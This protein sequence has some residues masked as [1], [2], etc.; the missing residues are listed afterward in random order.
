[1]PLKKPSPFLTAILLL[2][3]C[4]RVFAFETVVIDPGHGGVDQGSQ[5]YHVM[6]K[7]LTFAVAQRLEAALNILGV[8]T[9][10]TRRYDHY[11]ALDA[12]ATMANRIPNSLLVSIHFN[13]SSST[14]IFGYQCFY[15]GESSKLIATAIDQAM[16][17][18]IQSRNRGVTKQ[19]YAVLMRA[20]DCSVLLE[21]GFLSNKTEVARLNSV[22]G[23]QELAEVIATGIV[24]AKPI[25]NYDFPK[26]EIAE[27]GT[28]ALVT[29][30]QKRA[31]GVA[32]D[33]SSKKPS[34]TKGSSSSS[35]GKKKG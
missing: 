9:V 1:M 28:P 4:T 12:R 14:S 24:R 22:Q 13:A 15:Q 26:W 34:V 8:N 29:R 3:L 17:E 33:T 7:T 6:E 31:A 32:A 21:C 18:R 2:C 27:D 25:I 10:M 19:D 11:V 30:A 35:K 5:W 16:A 23:Q 20:T